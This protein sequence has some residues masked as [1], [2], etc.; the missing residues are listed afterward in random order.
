MEKPVALKKPHEHFSGDES[1]T[2][3]FE[4][5]AE[6]MKA[7]VHPNLIQVY[8][9]ERNEG[10]M[11]LIMELLDGKTLTQ[12]VSEQGPMEPKLVLPILRDIASACM[13]LH[14]K[15][16]VHRDLTSNNV[17]LLKKGG[18]KVLDLGLSK[19]QNE[20]RQLTSAGEL[21]GTPQYFPADS[22][23]EDRDGQ[24]LTTGAYDQFSW[25]VLAYYLLTA[26]YPIQITEQGQAAMMKYLNTVSREDCYKPTPLH[27]V[28]SRFGPEVSEVLAKAMAFYRSDRY[29]TIDEAYRA[30]EKVLKRY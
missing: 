27:E 10:Q 9:V 16:L 11:L 15:G 2:R 22:F 8:A 26:K 18:I 14:T 24:L 20:S 30:L 29:E 23:I 6:R 17:M 12:V 25:G 21:F 1:A 4:R 19:D 28:D 5:E 3:R 13:T 7:V